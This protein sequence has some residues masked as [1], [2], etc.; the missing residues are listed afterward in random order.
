[1]HTELDLKKAELKKQFQEIDE[2]LLSLGEE[3]SNHIN[4]AIKN[5]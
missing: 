2:S 5:L 1:M 4:N 3:L